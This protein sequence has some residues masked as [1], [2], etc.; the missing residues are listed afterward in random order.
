[1]DAFLLKP[2]TYAPGTTMSFNGLAKPEDRANVIAYLDAT[3][4]DMTEVEMPAADGAEDEAS[5][6]ADDSDTE[7]AATDEAASE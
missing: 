7:V 3:D 6:D 2:K 1:M 4:G 5:L